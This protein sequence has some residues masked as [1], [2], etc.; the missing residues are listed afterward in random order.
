MKIQFKQFSS[1]AT[2]SSLAT[3]V[4]AVMIFVQQ[5]TMKFLP[6]LFNLLK[7]A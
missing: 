5:A 3:E 6:I 1:K 2:E 7:R 4:L